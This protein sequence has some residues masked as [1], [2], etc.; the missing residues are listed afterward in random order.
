MA[1]T[2]EQEEKIRRTAENIADRQRAEEAGT[3][4]KDFREMKKRQDREA[5]ETETAKSKPKATFREKTA[6]NAK[7][8]ARWAVGQVPSKT[9]GK[10]HPQPVSRSSSGSNQRSS[11]SHYEK[12]EQG[13]EVDFSGFH[14]PSLGFDGFNNVSFNSPFSSGINTRK[15][16]KSWAPPKF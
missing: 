10:Y 12:L 7:Q 8:V 14:A 11:S 5:R 16:V 1:L 13:S 2:P 3:T 4:A 9:V 15:R 6:K